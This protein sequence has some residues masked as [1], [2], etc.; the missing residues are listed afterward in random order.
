MNGFPRRVI[1]RTGTRVLWVL[2]KENLYD[3]Y[4]DK[5]SR[6]F[7]VIPILW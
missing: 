5:R 6:H 2:R 7:D 3:T 1:V 4:Q